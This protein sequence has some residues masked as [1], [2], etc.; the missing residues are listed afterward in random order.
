MGITR[1]KANI[2]SVSIHQQVNFGPVSCLGVAPLHALADPP[3]TTTQ[4]D[5]ALQ[6]L[7]SMEDPALVDSGL[8]VDLGLFSHTDVWKPPTGEC[9]LI[10]HRCRH[11]PGFIQPEKS[12][13]KNPKKETKKE[14]GSRQE[15]RGDG[16]HSSHTVPHGTPLNTPDCGDL[17]GF[18][19]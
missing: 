14:A 16:S 12:P 7:Q 18:L 15:T 13:E 2:Q 4:L 6:A 1:R 19:V 5:A 9:I 11:G 8:R 17:P 3:S 10:G